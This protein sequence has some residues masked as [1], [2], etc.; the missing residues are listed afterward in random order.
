MFAFICCL[1]QQIAGVAVAQEHQIVLGTF[2]PVGAEATTQPDAADGTKSPALT[3]VRRPLY[4]LR[5]SDVLAVGFTFAPEFDETVSVQPDGFIS[6]K[7]LSQMYA[8]GLTLPELREQVA[9]AYAGTLHNPEVTIVLKDFDKPYFVAA[10][11]VRRPGKYELRADMTVTEAVAMAGGFSPQA[12]HSQV[13]L[14]RRVS[15]EWTE[16]RLVNVKSMLKARNL[17]EDLHLQPGDLIY[18]PQSMISKIERLVPTSNLSLY[19]N[20]AQF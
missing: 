19:A 13:V 5:R 3:G 17:H 14:F 15:D 7:G 2:G 1:G 11:E 4:R 9:R 8:Q 6:L 18:V 16:A 12:K 10:G 20:P